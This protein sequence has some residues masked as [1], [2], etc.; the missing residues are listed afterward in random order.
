[1]S[2]DVSVSDGISDVWID[3][4][5][6]KMI[7]GNGPIGAATKFSR[8]TL[9]TSLS[10]NCLLVLGS[11]VSNMPDLLQRFAHAIVAFSSLTCL[12]IRG[13]MVSDRHALIHLRDPMLC[14]LTGLNLV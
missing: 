6:A 8:S 10:L 9:C 12:L 4:A 3:N 7:Q 2:H 13:S 1:M 11:T 14:D 5:A